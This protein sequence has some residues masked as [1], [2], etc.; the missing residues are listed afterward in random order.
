MGFVRFDGAS[1]SVI[2]LVGSSWKEGTSTV[3][4]SYGVET[5][6]SQVDGG[7]VCYG[8]NGFYGTDV[9]LWYQECQEV[10][11]QGTRKKKSWVHVAQY[12]EE[13]GTKGRYKL[14]GPNSMQRSI[15]TLQRLGTIA[16]VDIRANKT[17][18]VEENP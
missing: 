13:M 5:L 3:P 10:R 14:R 12:N 4:G 2:S 7:P 15:V 11:P 18:Q 1:G 16:K 17:Y 6:D 8:P 9:A